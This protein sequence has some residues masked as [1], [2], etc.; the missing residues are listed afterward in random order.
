MAASY[1]VSSATDLGVVVAEMSVAGW[2]VE[3]YANYSQESRCGFSW[4]F[5]HEKGV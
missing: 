3:S 4:G 2:R 1:E 5:A